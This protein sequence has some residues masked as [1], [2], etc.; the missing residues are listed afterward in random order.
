LFG[1]GQFGSQRFGVISRSDIAL[2]QLTPPS[3]W[4]FAPVPL[5]LKGVR[6]VPA[7]APS[8][9]GKRASLI[10]RGRRRVR[11]CGRRGIASSSSIPTRRRS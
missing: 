6:E 3:P 10:I 2:G 5:P 1:R 4:R 8:S 7:L 9:L 11:R